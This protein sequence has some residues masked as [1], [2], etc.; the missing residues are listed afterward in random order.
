MKKLLLSLLI[1]VLGISLC[2]CGQS[3]LPNDDIESILDVEENTEKSE[4]TTQTENSK[5]E[6]DNVQL[7]ETG[8]ALTYT[9][10]KEKIELGNI[11]VEYPSLKINDTDI[12][13]DKINETIENTINEILKNTK[14]SILEDEGINTYN[15]FVSYEVEMAT[16]KIISIVFKGLISRKDG[17][18]PNNIFFAI[19]VN[20]K[21][22]EL[23]KNNDIVDATTDN[24]C[25]IFEKEK[26]YFISDVHKE[27]FSEIPKEE[28]LG[29]FEN[30]DVYTKGLLM[31]NA[32]FYFA[33]D[34]V[35][36]VLP[37]IHSLGDIAKVRIP[38][39]NF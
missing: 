7:F 18:Y 12:Q 5:E 11:S 6:T 17:V 16:D 25:D 1:L 20:P 36:I 2:A 35:Y 29:Y 4:T 22:G 8:E 10:T 31:N 9:E 38:Y 3:I 24:L 37:T 14:S 34:C 13:I 15:G 27:Y 32:S 23:I 19:N 28:L 21:T 30:I 26:C 33:D 39:S